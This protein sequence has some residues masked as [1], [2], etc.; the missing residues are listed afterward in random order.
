MPMFWHDGVFHT[1]A[2]ILSDTLVVDIYGMFGVFHYAKILPR[3]IG[4]YIRRS[5]L[6]DALF[7][8]ELLVKRVQISILTGSHY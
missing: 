8:A 3:Y 2:D 7:E 4:C 5:H 1:V 6:D